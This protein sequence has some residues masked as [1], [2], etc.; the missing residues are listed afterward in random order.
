MITRTEYIVTQ[1]Q[2]NELYY[3]VEAS[4]KA[5]A[6][7][8]VEEGEVYCDEQYSIRETIP[9]VD[10]VIDYNS[11]PNRGEAWSDIPLKD[12][13]RGDVK[14]GGRGWHYNGICGGEKQSTE[15]HCGKCSGAMRVGQRLLTNAEKVYLKKQYGECRDLN[16]EEQI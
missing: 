4:S 9:K 16:T 7:R 8:M 3:T 14:M 12:I 13:M 2:T 6:I 11:C 1:K 5:E 15:G 10:S